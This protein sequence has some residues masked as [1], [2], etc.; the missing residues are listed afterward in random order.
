[1]MAGQGDEQV[2]VNCTGHEFTEQQL[3]DIGRVSAD[4]QQLTMGHVDDAHQAKRDRQS[5][6]GEQQDAAQ[7]DAIE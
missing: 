4:H 5:Q 6:C 2:S 1:M 7:R 3:H